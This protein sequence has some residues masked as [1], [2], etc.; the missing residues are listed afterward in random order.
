[1]L[2]TSGHS[3]TA[4][5]CATD[6]PAFGAEF[7]TEI[8]Y[9]P[10]SATSVLLNVIISCLLLIKLVGRAAPFHKATEVDV[11]FAPCR[12]NWAPVLPPADIVPPIGLSNG[13]I[14]L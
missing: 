6:I 7:A 11:K 14:V 8:R 10:S 1:M 13:A 12:K 2:A 9:V 4:I 5:G 3:C